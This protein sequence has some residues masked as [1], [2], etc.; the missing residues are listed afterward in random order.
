MV[1]PLPGSCLQM[2]RK[3]GGYNRQGFFYGI[4]CHGTILEKD[5]DFIPNL[6]DD[7]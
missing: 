5:G 2:N 4:V 3:F 1:K 6:I 7:G